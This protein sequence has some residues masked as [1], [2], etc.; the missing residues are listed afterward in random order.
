MLRAAAAQEMGNCRCQLPAAGYFCCMSQPLYL[1]LDGRLMREE[2]CSI[3]PNNR[4]F[5]YGDGFFETI[6]LVEGRMPLQHLH[7]ERLFASLET[8]GFDRPAFLDA[9]YLQQQVLSVTE[10]NRHTAA[11]RVRITVFRG[12][13]GLFDPEN[14]FPHV[15][16]Q[17]WALQ[18]V[19]GPAEG[20]VTG[21]YTDARKTADRFSH[22]KSNNYLCYAMAARWA[23]EQ[24]LQEAILLNAFGRIADATIAN[25]FIVHNGIIKTPALTEGGVGGVMRLYLLAACRSAG[26]A[27]EETTVEPALLAEASEMFL[28]N[29]ISGIRWV[30][31]AGKQA[32]RYQT[33]RFLYE[34]FIRPLG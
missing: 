25:V 30:R 7:F 1:I 16:V 23:R 15:L 12:N 2:A 27:V 18:P 32:F 14:H 17:S 9:A 3:S 11:A 26:M 34:Q 13:G 8:L 4:S 21:I 31:L 5:R 10:K 29:A 19:T 24:G 20:L 6:K 28:T 22:I 33:G